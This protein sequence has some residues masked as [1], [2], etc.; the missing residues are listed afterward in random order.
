MDLVIREEDK[1]WIFK[2]EVAMVFED[3][4]KASFPELDEEEE[5]DI[6]FC[7]KHVPDDYVC[8][9]VLSIWAQIRNSRKLRKRYPRIYQPRCI[10]K[11]I[12]KYLVKSASY[13]IKQS[14]VRDVG[15]AEIRTII[16]NSRE[17]NDEL[18]KASEFILENDE[19]CGKAEERTLELHLLEFSGA[20]EESCLCVLPHMMCEYLYQLSKK[21]TSYYLSVC[22]VGSIAKTSTLLLCEA[23]AVV[24]E[25][26]FHLLGI[27]PG[28]TTGNTEVDG[29]SPDGKEKLPIKRSKGSLGS[30]NMI[31]GKKNEQ[32]KAAANGGYPKSAESGSEG[33][34]GNSENGSQMK[35]GSRQDSIEATSEGSQNGNSANGGPN[36][37]VNQTVSGPA[38]NLNIAMEYWNGANSPNMP[39]MHGKVASGSVAGGM[40]PGARESQIWLQ[41]SKNLMVGNYTFPWFLVSNGLQWGCIIHFSSQATYWWTSGSYILNLSDSIAANLGYCYGQRKLLF[42]RG[43][44][45]EGVWVNVWVKELSMLLRSQLSAKQPMDVNAPVAIEVA[46]GKQEARYFEDRCII[47]SSVSVAREQPRNSRFEMLSFCPSITPTS[48][49][50]KGRLFGFIAIS[51][52]YG[53]LSDGASHL[54]NPDFG[55]VSFFDLDWRHPVNMRSCG[56]INLGNP[57]SQHSVPF[58]SSIEIRMELYVTTK[59]REACFELCSHRATIELSDFWKTKSDSMCAYLDVKGEGGS[60]QLHYLLLKD[61]IDTV[62]KV[63]FRTKKIHGHKVSGYIYAYYGSEFQY[64]CADIDKALYTITLCQPDYPILLK[65]GCEI[66]LT[67][68]MIAVPK[69]GSLIIVAYLLEG[70][71]RQVLFD[72]FF[73]FILPTK[74]ND[75]KGS[76]EGYINGIEGEDC[77]LVLELGWKYQ[78]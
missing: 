53:I 77:S 42:R 32:N 58:S 34:D 44:E 78:A 2:D 71:S 50:E 33:S 7:P 68:S 60:T 70:E 10:G 72:D 9:N 43:E 76:C 24:M 66:C 62:L 65:D 74:G 31:T 18:K 8:K 63:R 55:Y 19:E 4:I 59:M 35:S 6:D 25:K 64:G 67:K 48:V 14:S 40:A 20:L 75:T 5:A 52:K 28:N 27:T 49:V 57:N 29:K 41:R 56:I 47:P 30:L 22:K 73:E 45:N 17:D 3:S 69:N 11:A 15:R 12:R 61:A 1:R 54:C 39:A 51:D 26:C 21:F 13:M 46:T 37:P 23:T 38:T 36:A 16:K